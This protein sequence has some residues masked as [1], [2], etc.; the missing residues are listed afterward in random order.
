MRAQT[1]ISR[2][3]TSVSSA[4]AALARSTLGDL[5]GKT[6]LVI[7]AGDA[8]TLAARALASNGVAKIIVT[9]R[10]PER[11]GELAAEL[12]GS[13]IPFDKLGA[14][15]AQADV[16]ITSTAAPHFLIQRP[17]IESAMRGRRARPILLIDIAVP[18]DVDPDV[19]AVRGVHLHDIDDLQAIAREGMRLR[20]KELAPA[21]AMVDEAAEKY[22]AWLRSL[23]VVPTV[24]ALRSR[25][26][27]LRIGELA[28]TL[29]RT[30]MSDADR[31]RV[32]AMTS[33]LV[34]KLLHAPV[35]RLKLPGEGERY[36]EATRALF[37]LETGDDER[38]A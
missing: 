3:T 25:A 20:R 27:A 21:Q 14:A 1:N 26:E 23:E 17:M 9:S 28:R 10:S 15:L 4:A 37:D 12:D 32:D 2:G 8:G 35:R 33:A 38:E 34:K 22:G 31:V 19:R 11:S 7:S 5:S 30:S 36:V 29:A 13:T 24:A 16:V 18:R 6:A